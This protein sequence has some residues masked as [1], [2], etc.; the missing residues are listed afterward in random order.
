MTFHYTIT[1]YTYTAVFGIGNE[2]VVRKR[3]HTRIFF[4]QNQATIIEKCLEKS[5]RSSERNDQNFES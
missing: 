2:E 1:F 4:V 5:F 3:V